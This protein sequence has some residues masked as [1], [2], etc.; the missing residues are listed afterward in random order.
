MSNATNIISGNFG[1]A[2]QALTLSSINWHLS[3]MLTKH[4]QLK[5]LATR[6]FV[7]DSRDLVKLPEFE[8]V[9]VGHTLDQL[10]DWLVASYLLTENLRRHKDTNER[11][12]TTTPY[13]YL[14]PVTPS[15]AINANFQWRA[16]MSGQEL[17]NKAM[18]MGLK[19]AAEI[20]AKA[21]K[22]AAERNNEQRAY[23]VAEAES[24]TNTNLLN[25]ATEDLVDLLT[26]CPLD[27][28]QIAKDAANNAV[29]RARARI[30]S[31]LWAS[32]DEEV[33][34]F[35]KSNGEKQLRAV[36]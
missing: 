26:S 10:C 20:S 22:I 24:S 27:I 28:E 6:G 30:E 9:A 3:G 21:A 13:A 32:V 33:I 19:N 12:Q 15:M 14:K 2:I 4:P 31:G 11:G 17:A 7:E 18:L 36:A 25:W 8:D 23:A 35:A 34:L 29:D 16:K 1:P 5:Q